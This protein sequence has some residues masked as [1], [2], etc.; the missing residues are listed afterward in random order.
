MVDHVDSP[1]LTALRERVLIGDGAMGTQ[2]QSFDLDVEKDFLGL[3]GCN[4]ILNDTRPDIL[5]TIHRRYFEAG[6]D[7]VETNTF[8]CN[9][10]N[11]ADYDIEDRI[12]E[13]GRISIASI[14]ASAHFSAPQLNQR[15]LSE[16]GETP[17][18]YINRR[19]TELAMALLS[20]GAS[21]TETA[22]RL[23]FASSQH[24]SSFF[25]SYTGC[26]PTQWRRSSGAAQHPGG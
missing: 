21:V 12:R 1:F 8:G 17:G 9:L 2:L 22:L 14:S 4:E 10:P 20:E 3:E 25:R 23:G 5:E 13:G 11:L 16:I 6:A 19:R 26:S 18:Q 15:F 24:F 7:L